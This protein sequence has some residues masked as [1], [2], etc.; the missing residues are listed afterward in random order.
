VIRTSRI[1]ASPTSPPTEPAAIAVISGPD[2]EAEGVTEGDDDVDMVDIMV[3]VVA[4]VLLGNKVTES[5]TPMIW[6]ALIGSKLFPVC[7]MSR[8]AQRGTVN[9]D[10]R[11]AGNI[12]SYL[13]GQFSVHVVQ[14]T[15]DRSWQPA[16]ALTREYVTVLHRQL[17]ASALVGPR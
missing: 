14:F 15:Y 8:Y 4:A 5:E 12:V 1:R 10:G 11:D 17:S 2:G 16:Q 13:W 3:V 9:V 7:D 6:A